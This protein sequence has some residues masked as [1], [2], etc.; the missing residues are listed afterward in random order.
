MRLD[1]LAFA[2]VINY[3]SR[4]YAVSITNA[5]MKDLDELMDFDPGAGMQSNNISMVN[6]L[7]IH[8]GKRGEKIE[9]IKA[10]RALTGQSLASSK[11]YIDS[12]WIDRPYTKDDPV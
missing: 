3:I 8:M 12:S 2:R 10:Y 4:Q 9:A 1:K 6:H 11:A 7:V 5:E